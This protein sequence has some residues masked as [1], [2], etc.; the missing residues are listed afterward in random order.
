MRINILVKR[1]I[2]GL[3]LGCMGTD[4]LAQTPACSLPASAPGNYDFDMASDY[5][6]ANPDAPT[7]YYKLAVNWSAAHCEKIQAELHK[8]TNQKTTEKLQQENQFQCF[9]GNRFGWILHGLWASSCA[10]KSLA[11]CTDLTEIKNH[12]R[13]C[14]GDLPALPFSEIQPYLCMSPGAALLQAEWEKHG[15]CDFDSAPAY[16]EKS[17]ELFD[18][19]KLPQQHMS[20]AEL[21]S[22]MKHHNPPLKNKRLLFRESEM[23][24]CYDTDFELIDCPPRP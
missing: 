6:G 10:G 18:A 21:E 11:Q 7:D 12:P 22:W 2:I 13:F 24:I 8:A 15:A 5:F 16:F 17:K 14:R 4:A 19:L 23:Y 20:H 1:A 3:F 9:S